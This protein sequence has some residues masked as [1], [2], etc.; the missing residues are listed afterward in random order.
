MDEKM[1]KLYNKFKAIR[2]QGYITSFY[3]YSHSAGLTF[4]RLLGKE[5]DEL[6]WPDYEGIEIKTKQ[7]YSNSRI[8]L[9]TAVPDGKYLYPIQYL[10][11]TY[12][13]EYN[14]NKTFI[15]ELKANERTFY[16]KKIF[17]VFVDK[18]NKW[19]VLKIYNYNKEL[20]DDSIV[21]SFDLIRERINIKLQKLALVKCCTRREN[22]RDKY[23]YYQI[24]FYKE[25]IFDKFLEQFEKGNISIKFAISTFKSGRRSGQIHN[26]GTTFAIEE[27]NLE[28][29]YLEKYKV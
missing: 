26:H 15:M 10:Y 19:I 7:G 20:I 5:R 12:G 2:N 4:E 23:W 8:S 9:F 18:R 29:I 16:N 24:S 14:G 11:D 28:D 27:R 25:I 6:Y 1:T 22:N 3:D 17:R 13:K 21:W